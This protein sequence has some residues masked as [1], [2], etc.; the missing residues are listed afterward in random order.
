MG[1]A[2]MSDVVIAGESAQF[3]AAFFRLGAVPDCLTL[4]LLPRLIGLARARN[5]LLT[6]ATLS[7]TDAVA[8]GLA[9]KVVP[10]DQ[11]VW[12]NLV[13]VVLTAAVSAFLPGLRALKSSPAEALRCP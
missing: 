2:L 10:D 7:A 1:V 4:F 9:A 6:N 11:A 3:M 5:M 8:L 13:P 12:L